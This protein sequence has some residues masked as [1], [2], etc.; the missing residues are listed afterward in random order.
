[1]RRKD[2]SKKSVILDFIALHG[3]CKG[4]KIAV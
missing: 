3:R 2:E 4:K 1:M